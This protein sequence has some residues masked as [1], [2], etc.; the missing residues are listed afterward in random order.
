MKDLFILLNR[1]IIILLL[2]ILSS[3]SYIDRNI[4]QELTIN[5]GRELDNRD[6]ESTKWGIG[7]RIK[8]VWR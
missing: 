6:K 2:F 7:S 3:C 4:E 8:W 1:Y 5:I